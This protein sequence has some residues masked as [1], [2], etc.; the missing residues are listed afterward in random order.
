MD[1]PS[2]ALVVLWDLQP[3]QRDPGVVNAEFYALGSHL[4]N[5][6][7]CL[8]RDGR[9]SI[10]G[11]PALRAA[12]QLAGYLQNLRVQTS[13]VNKYGGYFAGMPDNNPVVLQGARISFRSR[14]EGKSAYPN[15]ES[16]GR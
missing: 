7:A 13:Q 10:R 6:L 12:F 8:D 14:S 15:D 16:V 4:P 11:A 5:H 1:L 3:F 9:P 2:L